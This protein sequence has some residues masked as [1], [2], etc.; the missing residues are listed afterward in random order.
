MLTIHLVSS[1]ILSLVVLIHARTVVRRPWSSWPL[2]TRELALSAAVLAAS[3]LLCAS[4]VKDEIVSTAGVFY[5]LAVYLA[6]QRLFAASGEGRWRG[7]MLAACIVVAAPLWAFRAVGTHYELRRTA[8]VTRNDWVLDATEP[9]G[10]GT[11]PA[12]RARF[13]ALRG[14]ALLHRVTSPSFLPR[15]GDRY[16][17]SGE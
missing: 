9:S 2:G 15:W 11:S 5:A 6:L 13:S 10:A 16:W 1:L 14:E 8:F 4:Y 17:G 7:A 3:A 12:D